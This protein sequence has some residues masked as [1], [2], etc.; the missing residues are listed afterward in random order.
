MKHCRPSGQVCGDGTCQVSCPVG[1]INCGGTCIVPGTDRDHCGASGNCLLANAGAVCAA[2]QVCTSGACQVSCPGGQINCTGTCIVPGTDRN[3]CGATGDCQAGNS[4]DACTSGQVC[5]LGVCQVSCQAGLTN[6]SGTCTNVGSNPANCNSCGNICPG[7]VNAA[8]ACAAGNCGFVCN[9][10]FGDCD[11]SRP[12]GCETSLL[13]DIN[14]C[15]GCGTVCS[16]G[17]TCAGGTCG[18]FVLTNDADENLTGNNWFDQCVT[19]VGNNVA[20]RLID[21]LGATVYQATG[22]KVGS[23]T[24]D[25]VTFSGPNTWMQFDPSSHAN[26][27]VLDNGDRLHITGRSSSNGGCHGSLGDGYGIIITDSS[28]SIAGI[29]ILVMGYLGGMGGEERWLQG[30]SPATEITYNSAGVS[31]S[32]SS[33]TAFNG[34]FAFAVT[35]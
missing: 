11:A 12:N 5:S 15:G 3:H 8:P 22:V 19:A 13:T 17:S 26:T 35:P 27:I 20:V 23:W 2:G 28:D 7:R 31:N 30:W 16:V 1:Q 33:T 9:A 21:T 18:C 25:N 24:F 29:R 10:N 14:N 34:T 6:C 4:G 32:C